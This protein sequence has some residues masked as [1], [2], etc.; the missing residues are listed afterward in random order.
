MDFWEILDMMAD[1]LRRA[2]DLSSASGH[3]GSA[4]RD[5]MVSVS[6]LLSSFLS[7]RE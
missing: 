1:F 4:T 6:R 2:S 7:H 3:D 5:L